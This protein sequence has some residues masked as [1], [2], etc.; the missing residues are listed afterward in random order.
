MIIVSH[1]GP[2]SFTREADGSLSWRPGAGG[3]ASALTPL[4]ARQ[5]GTSWVAAAMGD[6]DKAAAVAGP[7]VVDEIELRLVTLDAQLHQMHYDVVS[8]STLWF[9]HHGLFD[10]PRRPRFDARFREAWH[11]YETVNAVFADAVCREA[12]EGEIVL[13]QDYQLALVPAFV[14]ERRPDLRAALFQHTPFCGP[15]SVRVLPEY[16]AQ[17]LLAA[18]ASV[19]VGFHTDRWGRAYEASA[20]EILG[21]DHPI[22]PAFAAALGPDVDTLRDTAATPEAVEAGLRFRAR[23]GD[24]RVILR[25]DRIEPSKNIVRGFLAYELLLESHPEWRDRVA[26]L[27]LL[28]GSRESLPEYQ[29]YRQEVVATA[30]RI[31][32]RWGTPDW[33]PITLET[34]DNFARSIAGMQRYDVLLVNPIKDGLNLVAKEGPLLNQRDGVLCLSR[35]AGSHVELGEAAL[36]V[37]PYD[38][39]QMA[40]A[41]LTGLEMPADTRA[42]RAARLRELAAARNPAVWLADLIA[43]ADD[44]R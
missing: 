31:N 37:N 29:S 18:M 15:Q 6:G 17:T 25:T 7:Q 38:L 24:R 33:Q 36:T 5:A 40:N 26:F 43:H 41:M 34:D 8:N 32:A 4:L 12:D 44:G 22:V 19:P 1:R 23:V 2:F 20:R 11:A 39:E 35:E 30:A 14:R 28:Y 16:A 13:V 27:A 42:T 3:V 9:L 21:A 10:L